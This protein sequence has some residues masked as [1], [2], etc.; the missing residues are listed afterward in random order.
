MSRHSY[1]ITFKDKV[2]TYATKDNVH[3]VP[4]R[5][6]DKSQMKLMNLMLHDIAE[7]RFNCSEK[8]FYDRL[9][10]TMLQHYKHLKKNEFKIV[11]DD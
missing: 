4:Y 8:E 11:T 10:P 3:S 2:I 9:T 5:I 7:P 6:L 1:K